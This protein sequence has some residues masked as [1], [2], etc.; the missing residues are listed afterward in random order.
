MEKAARAACNRAG[1]E[2]SA[3]GGGVLLAALIADSPPSLLE[4][5]VRTWEEVLV[6]GLPANEEGALVDEADGPALP[7]RW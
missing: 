1:S 5:C 2:T 3:S 4:P 6:A 7:V